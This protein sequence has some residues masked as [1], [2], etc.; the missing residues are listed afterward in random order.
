MTQRKTGG[1]VLLAIKNI[2]QCSII[3]TPFLT[4]NFPDIDLLICKCTLNYKSFY[5]LLLYIPPSVSLELLTAFL[6]SLELAT[7]LHDKHLL[8]LD[9]FNIPNF[10]DQNFNDRALFTVNHFINFYGSQQLN[11]IPN[12]LNRLLD[13]VISNLDCTVSLNVPPIVKEDDYHP[14]LLI[15]LH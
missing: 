3:D 6:E 5:I 4:N 8:V 14:S 9:D 13:L 11:N 15:Y 1:G 2:I 12:K 7:F 10:A